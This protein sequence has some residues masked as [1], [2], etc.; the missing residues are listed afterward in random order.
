MLFLLALYSLQRCLS[1]LCEAASSSNFSSPASVVRSLLTSLGQLR[2]LHEKLLD[3]LT[4]WMTEH[5]T[6]LK[7]KDLVTFA[8]TT[9]SLNYVPRDSDALYKK[10]SDEL[11]YEAVTRSRRGGGVRGGE[12][13]GSEVIWLDVV[14]SLAVLKR[15]S[16]EQLSSVLSHDYYNKLLC[17]NFFKKV[18]RFGIISFI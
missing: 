4:S 8:L 7:E 15:C 18:Y 5:I 11:S 14:W 6:E 16:A 12:G 1:A 17:K 3:Q 9:A 13:S 10:I 2:F